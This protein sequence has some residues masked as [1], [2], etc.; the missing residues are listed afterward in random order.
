MNL[1]VLVLLVYLLNLEAIQKA[2]TSQPL[3]T[4]NQSVTARLR[5]DEADRSSSRNSDIQTARTHRASQIG[6][7]VPLN[8]STGTSLNLHS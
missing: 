5:P 8:E 1:R 4:V 7:A 2:N 3:E 6:V